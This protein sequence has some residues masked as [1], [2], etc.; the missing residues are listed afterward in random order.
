[1]WRGV[2]WRRSACCGKWRDRRR[3]GSG[4]SYGSVKRGSGLKRSRRGIG[5]CFVCVCVLVSFFLYLLVVH[6][7]LLFLFF[8]LS[9][10]FFCSISLS[11][12][13]AVCIAIPS[14]SC[15]MDGD[16]LLLSSLFS[17]FILFSLALLFPLCDPTLSLLQ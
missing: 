15:L 4:G 8:L 17:F 6:R 13:I 7:D 3:N 11:F 5:G 10:L 1:M 12:L 2:S 9:S 14:F 16:L